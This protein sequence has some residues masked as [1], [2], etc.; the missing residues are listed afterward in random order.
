[1]LPPLAQWS[2]GN[3]N[4]FNQTRHHQIFVN[5]SAENQAGAGNPTIF[6][7]CTVQKKY[8]SHVRPFSNGEGRAEEI[9]ACPLVE[10]EPLVPVS[11]G[12]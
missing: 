5:V 4:A 11:E 8:S 2:K 9:R 7:T 6:I 12:F 1:M 10:N 3:S